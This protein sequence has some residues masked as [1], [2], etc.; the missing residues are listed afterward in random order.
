[1]TLTQLYCPPSS[2]GQKGP[3]EIKKN[4]KDRKITRIHRL[5]SYKGHDDIYVIKAQRSQTKFIKNTTD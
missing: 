4:H 1:M 2:K 3:Q 5:Y